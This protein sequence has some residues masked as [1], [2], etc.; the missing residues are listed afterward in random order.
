MSS[1]TTA[2]PA[3]LRGA[4]LGL[5]L[6]GSAAATQA[7]T[8]YGLSTT[9]NI[10]TTSL[11]TFNAT[12]PG[13]FAT[14]VPITGFTAGQAIVGIDVRPNT[15]ELFALGYNPT[16]T[17]AQ[18]YTINRTTGVVTA[19]GAALTL[20]LGTTTARIGFDFNPTVDRIRV[21]SAAPMAVTTPVVRL[22]V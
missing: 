7:Q 9:S 14:T 22:M 6:L 13:T 19:I 11:V 1:T 3:L 15:G 18:L 16:G 4:L 17:Q 5:T 10:A 21:T 12:T 20:N 8:I 2:A